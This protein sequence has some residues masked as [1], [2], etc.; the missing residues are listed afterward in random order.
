MSVG[1]SSFSEN[2]EWLPSAF[3]NFDILLSINYLLD[4][5]VPFCLGSRSFY[6]E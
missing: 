1:Y 5:L 4:N 3:P 6:E 2:A